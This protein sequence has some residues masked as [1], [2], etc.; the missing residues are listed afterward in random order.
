MSRL[1]RPRLGE[2][3]LSRDRVVERAL[4]LA[5]AEGVDAITMRRLGSELG[6]EAMA[7]Y[8]HVDSKDDLLSAVGSRILTELEIEPREH[9][10]WRGRIET[11]CRAWAALRERHPN[12][13]AL[14]YR[15]DTG[16]VPVTEELM[17][18]LLTAGL[19][20]AD[21]WLAYQTLVFFLDAPLVHWPKASSPGDV[22]PLGR[23][24]PIQRE[25]APYA[26]R[27]SW[28]DVWENGLAL[29]LD[30]LEARLRR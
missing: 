7:L 14:I 11:V 16:V 15:A 12:T 20:G 28:D 22:S 17:D 3:T 30:G 9:P 18:A 25:L 29:F 2:P 23:G 10:D 8:T 19:S 4:E 24:G 26:R 5:D 6:V 27:Y 1:G 13:F 21:A